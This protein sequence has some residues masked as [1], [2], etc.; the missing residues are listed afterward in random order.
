M[1]WLNSVTDSTHGRS[2]ARKEVFLPLLLCLEQCVWQRLCLHCGSSF[3]LDIPTVRSIL[4]RRSLPEDTGN[5][6]SSLWPQPKG[7]DGSLLGM[8]PLVASLIPVWLLS[9]SLPWS[10][11]PALNSLCWKYLT[12]GV[13]WLNPPW[14][15]DI[16]KKKR[17]TR[18][19]GV[20]L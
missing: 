17:K 10:Q 18:C 19:C 4:S 8:K 3:Q 7:G 1:G 20:Y 13:S 15:H 2:R 11:Y 12:K 5:I 6:I 9:S 14:H 16:R